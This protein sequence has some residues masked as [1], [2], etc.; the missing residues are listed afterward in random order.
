MASISAPSPADSSASSATST[1][2]APSRP[3]N[4]VPAAPLAVPVPLLSRAPAPTPPPSAERT[5]HQHLEEFESR[6]NV[7]D[8]MELMSIDEKAAL[9]ELLGIKA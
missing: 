9:E 1:P 4:H 8:Q 3:P 7:F 2:C 5:Q 6:N